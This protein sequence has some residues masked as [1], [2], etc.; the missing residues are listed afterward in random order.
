[1]TLAVN[2]LAFLL[3]LYGMHSIAL[4]VVAILINGYSAGTKLQ[5]C[6]YLTASYAGLRNIG[7]IFGAMYSMMALGSGAGPVIAGFVY[8]TT[9]GYTPFLVAG[10]IGCVLGGLLI[11]TLPRYPDWKAPQVRTPIRPA[12]A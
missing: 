1:L 3:L 7:A 11:L 9:G 5:I 10:A 6:T 4:I 8:D 2:S 12:L